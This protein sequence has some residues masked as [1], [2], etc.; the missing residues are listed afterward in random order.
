[1][2][3]NKNSELKELKE[4]SNALLYDELPVLL[5]NKKQKVF[6]ESLSIETLDQRDCFMCNHKWIPVKLS[7]VHCPKCAK[8]LGLSKQA[9]QYIEAFRENGEKMDLPILDERTRE[10]L[11]EEAVKGVSDIVGKKVDERL[12][13]ALGNIAG[14]FLR[15]FAPFIEDKL[16]EIDL[17]DFKIPNVDTAQGLKVV[18][19][20]G[21]TPEEAEKYVRLLYGESA[22][23]SRGVPVER[24]ITTPVRAKVPQVIEEKPMTKTEKP[25]M[26]TQPTQVSAEEENLIMGML[27]K[28]TVEELE[29]YMN[30]NNLEFALKPHIDQHLNDEQR[31]FIWENLTIDLVYSSLEQM[32]PDLMPLLKSEKGVKWATGLIKGVKHFCKPKIEAE[33]NGAKSELKETG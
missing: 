31:K 12:G 7:S 21:A 16:A 5:P 30:V 13:S 2:I 14:I 28:V 4:T 10:G 20:D 1:M 23:S 19:I 25:T 26:E 3:S 9:M 27:A 33:I 11:I 8:K 22:I 32:R 29:G 18:K 6:L 17:G 15:K 24:R